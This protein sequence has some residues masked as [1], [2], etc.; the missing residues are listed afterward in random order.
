[1]N[2]FGSA[3]AGRTWPSESSALEWGAAAIVS[4]AGA[5]LPHTCIGD[6]NAPCRQM[7]YGLL[8]LFSTAAMAAF[9]V[10]DL[11]WIPA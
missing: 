2:S 1:M 6:V 7:T 5:Y 4:S 9:T 3:S 8:I 10:E 11:T